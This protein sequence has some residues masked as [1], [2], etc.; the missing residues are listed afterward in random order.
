MKKFLVSVCMI[1]CIF[2]LTSCGSDKTLSAYEQ[3]KTNY[4]QQT[5]TGKVLPI[6]ATL[7]DEANAGAFDEYTAEEIEYMVGN[8]YSINADGYAIQKGIESFRSAVKQIGA[9]TGI[10]D[11]SVEIDGNEI[12]IHVTVN[13]ERKNADAELIFSNDMFLVLQSAALNPVSSLGE[14]MGKAGLNTL[15]GMGT[16]FSVLIL[17]SLIISCFRIIP[18]LQAK[19]EKKG[20]KEEIKSEGVDKAVAQ[21]VEQEENADVTDDLELVA[22]IAAAVAASEGAVTTDG[23]VVRSVRRVNRSRR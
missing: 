15:I 14:K 19:F 1:A 8:D 20:K 9:I 13:G 16:V 18:K 10:G 6:L 12:I 23:F 21:I 17:I 5:A 2:G 22:V 11:S 7:S 4:A 3:Q